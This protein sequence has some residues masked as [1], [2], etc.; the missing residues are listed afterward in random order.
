MIY[1][2]NSELA[3]V[4][5]PKTAGT[6][7]RVA[8]RSCGVDYV[9]YSEIDPKHEHFDLEK[10]VELLAA[11]PGGSL[12][13]AEN[14][15]FFTLVRHPFSWLRSYWVDRQLK[16]WGGNLQIGHECQCDDF[17]DFVRK[18]AMK[19]PNFITETFERYTGRLHRPR[20]DILKMEELPGTLANYLRGEYGLRSPDLITRLAPLNVGAAYPGFRDKTEGDPPLFELVAYAEPRIYETLGYSVEPPPRLDPSKV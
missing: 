20:A 8:I 4:H 7:V 3:F 6:W 1:L 9:D 19:F 13:K 16:G 18:C 5:I 17:P 14:T 12:A 15:N 2:P 11:T 10:A